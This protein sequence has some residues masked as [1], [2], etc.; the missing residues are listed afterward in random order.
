MNNNATNYLNMLDVY[1]KL[2]VEKSEMHGNEKDLI[3]S[4]KLNMLEDELR[5]YILNEIKGG[6]VSSEFVK[7]LSEIDA[8]GIMN[9]YGFKEYTYSSEL[10]SVGLSNHYVIDVNSG[11]EISLIGASLYNK[12]ALIYQHTGVLISYGDKEII[13]IKENKFKEFLDNI[14]QYIDINTLRD[15]YGKNWREEVERI[16][17]EGF[18]ESMKRQIQQ[19]SEQVDNNKKSNEKIISEYLK[20]EMK[21]GN[22]TLE[23]I[24]IHSEFDG[25]V[26]FESKPEE[27]KEIIQDDDD[28]K[29]MY[30]LSSDKI[31]SLLTNE[32]I[33][34]SKMSRIE[35]IKTI[36]E[37]T[38][39]EINVEDPEI[40]ALCEKRCQE[41]LRGCVPSVYEQKYGENWQEVVSKIYKESY[42]VTVHGCIS[43]G[44]N[45]VDLKQQTLI[46]EAEDKANERETTAATLEELKKEANNLTRELAS[47]KGEIEQLIGKN[48]VESINDKAKMAIG[49]GSIH[50]IENLL[51]H[52][53]EDKKDSFGVLKDPV[54]AEK[55]N[56]KYKSE[57]GHNHPMYDKHQYEVVSYMLS[58]DAQEFNSSLTPRDVVLLTLIKQKIEYENSKVNSSVEEK[59]M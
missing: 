46:K 2:I 9:N 52:Y 10:N 47:S 30:S 23:F 39:V 22:A 40:V 5:N 51:D 54:L 24:K 18:D 21:R 45:E 26:D 55:L 58:G 37:H 38:G 15:K 12:I 34:L 41:F 48:P 43:K 4:N 27:D 42:I 3:I 36:Y 6:N 19:I 49:N 1:K 44:L 16:Y 53:Y 35:K 7:F 13:N 14:S 59:S 31:T 56:N 25:T 57:L 17:K 8:L 28:N 20:K 11:K 32:E 50:D 33:D 29:N